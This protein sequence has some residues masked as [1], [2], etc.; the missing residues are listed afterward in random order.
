VAV[1]QDLNFLFDD[2][3]SHEKLSIWI[4]TCLLHMCRFFCGSVLGVNRNM[5][6][7]GSA[8]I[9]SPDVKAISEFQWLS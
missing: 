7:M 3:N 1:I 5:A 2:I 4:C 8:E 6:L 9:L